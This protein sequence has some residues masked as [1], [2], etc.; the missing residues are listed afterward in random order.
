MISMTRNKQMLQATIVRAVDSL[1][2]EKQLAKRDVEDATARK[3]AA[4]QQR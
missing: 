4:E 2:T 1:R 3:H